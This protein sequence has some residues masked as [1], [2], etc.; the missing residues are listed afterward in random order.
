[1]IIVMYTNMM[2]EPQ[3]LTSA[4]TR[5]VV[6]DLVTSRPYVYIDINIYMYIKHHIF[7]YICIQNATYLLPYLLIYGYLIYIYINLWHLVRFLPIPARAY[8][9]VI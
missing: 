5:V 7:I 4:A 2:S 6:D 9:Q 3:L 8:I 1:L